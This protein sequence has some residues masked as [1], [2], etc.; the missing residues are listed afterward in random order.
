MQRGARGNCLRCSPLNPALGTFDKD[1]LISS[2]TTSSRS[3]FLVFMF[4]KTENP[5]S[6]RYDVENCSKSTI[7]IARPGELNQVGTDTPKDDRRLCLNKRS[8]GVS[9]VVVQ[10]NER[11][12]CSTSGNTNSHCEIWS[13]RDLTASFTDD[14]I[15][16]LYRS[17]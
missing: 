16:P 7:A 3:R 5:L 8:C 13:L 2:S 10:S 1:T 11:I 9:L 14:Q 6:H 17:H 12:E 4:V 15:I